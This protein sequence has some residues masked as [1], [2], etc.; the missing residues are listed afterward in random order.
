VSPE[1]VLV[2][3]ALAG[4][5]RAALGTS[6]TV[7][8]VRARS[9]APIDGSPT[10]V[11]LRI[12]DRR[13]RRVPPRRA[14]ILA[15]ATTSAALLL[16]L[17]VVWTHGDAPAPHVG[18]T[19]TQSPARPPT[20]ASAAGEP[21]ATGARPAGRRF[22][23]APTAGSTGYHVELFRGS[24]RVF[25]EDTTR[26]EVVVPA[27]WTHE[28]SPQ[29]LSSGTYRWYVWPVVAGRRQSRATVQTTVTISNA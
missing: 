18:E 17:V 28:G 19:A 3:P 2:D 14:A 1:L 23:W 20:A 25:A 4:R 16:L 21:P 11:R 22:A 15:A 9:D 10:D 13:N 26:P 7:A 6:G 5:A 8:R 24:T 29:S 12:V 27:S